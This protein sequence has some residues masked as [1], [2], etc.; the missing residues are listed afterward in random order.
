[1]VDETFCRF[2]DSNFDSSTSCRNGKSVQ[3]VSVYFSKNK[4]LHHPDESDPNAINQPLGNWLI[5]PGIVP[6]LELT[7]SL[8][9][10]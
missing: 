6:Y 9:C 7:V 1:M 3:R 2:M 5:T 8:C 4:A 10:W